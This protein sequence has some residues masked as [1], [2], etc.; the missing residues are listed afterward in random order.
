MKVLSNHCKKIV[1][2]T[3][4]G[5]FLAMLFILKTENKFI[6]IKKNCQLKIRLWKLKIEIPAWKGEERSCQPSLLMTFKCYKTYRLHE[7][8]DY[9]KRRQVKSVTNSFTLHLQKEEIQ[10]GKW[11]ISWIVEEY[12][13]RKFLFSIKKF[14]DLF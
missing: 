9:G 7:V 13:G 1:A 8:Y 6:I 5:F 12:D 11:I 2:H 3:H 4:S 10:K 14:L